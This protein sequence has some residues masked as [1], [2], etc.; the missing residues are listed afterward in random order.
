[1]RQRFVRGRRG[2]PIGALLLAALAAGGCGPRFGSIAGTVTYQGKPIRWGCVKVIWMGAP[3]PPNAASAV[4]NQDGSYEVGKV[5]AGSTVKIYLQV[6]VVPM[7]GLLGGGRPNPEVIKKLQEKLGYVELPEKYTQPDTSGYSIEV[8]QGV[9]VFDIDV[10]AELA[11]EKKPS[12]GQKP[13]EDAKAPAAKTS[14]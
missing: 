1:M 5:P 12:A 2:I 13:A 6:P 9:N 8:K 4:L 14:S 3:G 11:G 7:G 10:P